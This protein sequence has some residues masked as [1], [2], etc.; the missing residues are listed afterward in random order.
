MAQAAAR[1]V[2]RSTSGAVGRSQN[3]LVRVRVSFYDDGQAFL[4]DAGQLLSSD[5]LRYSVIATN[6]ERARTP[7]QP[8]WFA[9]VLRD[10]DSI[11]GVA[12]RTHPDPPHAGFVT[13]MP[14]AAVDALAMALTRR[15]EVVLA[16][17]GNLTAASALCQAASG[18]SPVWV[19]MHTRLFEAHEV[20]WPPRPPGILRNATAADADLLANWLYGFHHDSE[21]QGGREPVLSWTPNVEG[22]R[23]AIEQQSIGLWEVDGV[24]VHMTGVQRAMFGAARIGPVYTPTEHRG[25][26]YASWV[27]A[28]LTQQILDTG[29]RPCLYTD[30]ANPVSNKI[31]ERLGYQRVHDEGNVI[32]AV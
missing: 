8:F 16:W 2:E 28:H 22:A 4:R 32:T 18:G 6:A 13:A 11:A 7:E 27:V 20:I 14:D 23:R 24:P 17:N 5:P 1:L 25:R 31:Y 3:R 10:D 26:G 29:D 21:T 30:Q 15:N 12:M 9:T 19:V